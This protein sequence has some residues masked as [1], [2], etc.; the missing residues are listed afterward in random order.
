M[1]TVEQMRAE[2][3]AALAKLE[4]EHAIAALAPIA[5]NS[6][7]LTGCGE[8]AWLSYKVESLWQALDVM[9]A[10]RPLA[11]YKFKGTYTR[12]EPPALNEART[13]DKGE[14]VDGPYLATIGVS[15]GEGFGPCV[16]FGFFVLL[17]AD[18]CKVKCDLGRGY[19]D[20]FGLYGARFQAET[21]GQSRLLEGQRYIA[22][23]FRANGK[24]S[25]YADLTQKYGTGS[26]EAAQ[27]AYS[28]SSDTDDDGLASWETD[29]IYRLENL[30]R[31]MHGEKPRYR[32]DF[33]SRS[34]T[35][36]LVR[37]EDNKTSLRYTGGDA[38]QLRYK[39]GEALN[40]EGD[41]AE[42]S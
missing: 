4:A 9:K 33:D 38:N 28:F 40:A 13:R 12:V 37:L 21:R 27:F 42:F 15:Q 25:S 2:H 10:F 14:E 20:S 31:D 11:C 26:R 3:A 39:A 29:A 16:S 41:S 1:K 18:I 36:V 19:S 22:G 34:G 6:A 17:G 8:K 32:Y 5:P 7:M 24:L 30:A 35:G 23:D